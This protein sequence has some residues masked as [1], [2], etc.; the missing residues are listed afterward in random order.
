M[1]LSDV[2]A[3]RY[4]RFLA[5]VFLIG[6]FAATFTSV[7]GVWHGVSLMFADF[8][9]SVRNVPE[10]DPRRGAGGT[11]YRAYILLLTIPPIALLFLDRPIA[12][13]VAYGALGSLFMPF[14][15]ITLLLL[16]NSSRVPE[17]W[18]NRWWVNAVLVLVTLLFLT[19]G[20]NELLKALAPLGLLPPGL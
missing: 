12:L 2:L 19:L 1:D 6:F 7:L 18:R 13:V 4:G 16:M 14:L 10:D 3:D 5:V 11:Y 9:A 8:V 15:A 17:R 20:V